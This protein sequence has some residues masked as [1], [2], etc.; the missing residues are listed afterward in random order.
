M[1]KALIILLAAA[2]LLSLSACGDKSPVSNTDLVPYEEEPPIQESEVKLSDLEDVLDQSIKLPKEWE[3]TRCTLIDESVSQV[4][5]TSG[6]QQFVGRY[7]KGQEDNLSGMEK[8]FTDTETVDINGVSV[9]IR[10]TDPEKTNNKRNFGVADAYDPAK[11]IS[12]CIIQKN[13]T[14]VE[15]LSSAMEGLMDSIG[16]SSAPETSAELD[17][18]ELKLEEEICFS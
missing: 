7:A 13:F 9:T 17:T 3:L 6:E 12:F 15:D 16:S 1:K 14:S 8:S 4:E 18:E 11:D 2:L 10:Y 5:I